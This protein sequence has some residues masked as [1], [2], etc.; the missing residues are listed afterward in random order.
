MSAEPATTRQSF[1]RRQEESSA[2][3]CIKE[4]ARISFFSTLSPKKTENKDAKNHRADDGIELVPLSRETDRG[5]GDA[6]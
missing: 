3:S 4:V 1:V 2:H 6:N 5:K